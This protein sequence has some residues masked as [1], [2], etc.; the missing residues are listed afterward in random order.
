[1]HENRVL[2]VV[3]ASLL[4]RLE[5]VSRLGVASPPTGTDVEDVELGDGVQRRPGLGSGAG[6]D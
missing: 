4:P 2:G 3:S 5:V 1:M 6:S